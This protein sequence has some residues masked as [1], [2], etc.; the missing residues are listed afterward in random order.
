MPVIDLR[1]IRTENHWTNR[2]KDKVK[3]VGRIVVEKGGE[4]VEF[5]KDNPQAAGLIIGAVT[6]VT[7][8]VKCVTRFIGKQSKQRQEN[9]HRKRQVYD[10]SLG[11]FLTTTRELKKEDYVKINEIRRKTGKRTSEVLAELNLLKK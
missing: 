6:T 2:L 1:K 3:N 9:F 4:A 5:I 8:G 10:H 7:G 11:M